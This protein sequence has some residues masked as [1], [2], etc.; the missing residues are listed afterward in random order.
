[1]YRV[2]III[3]FFS[4]LSTTAQIDSFQFQHIS[5]ED[6]LSQSSAIAIEQDAL[7]QMW[8]GTRDG[9]NVYDGHKITVF[10][11]DGENENS[12]S[13]S[14]ILSLEKDHKGQIWIGT[15]NGLNRYNPKTNTFTK[16]LKTANNNS[17]ASNIIQEVYST[18]DGNMWIGTSKGLS[19][20]NPEENTFYNGVFEGVLQDVVVYSVMEL[21]QDSFLIGT[22]LG[23]WAVH[24]KQNDSYEVLRYDAFHDDD[25]TD[26]VPAGKDRLFIGTKSSGVL[27]YDAI[28]NNIQPFKVNEELKI[29]D[30]RKLR[31]DKNNRLW[32]GSY[33]GIYIYDKG[34]VS[35]LI[36]NINDP[37]SLA[38]NSVKSL[39]ED[40]SGSIWVGTH[41]G[42]ANI[43]NEA[44][45]NFQ[46]YVQNGTNK[47]LN[48]S[49]VNS[50]QLFENQLFIGTEQG[51]V[52]VLDLEKNNF[53]YITSDNSALKENDIKSL[54]L[55]GNLLY[56]GT[57]SKGID[58]YN[59][60][61]KRFIKDLIS[62]PL[63][64]ELPHT[65]VYSIVKD[66][67][68]IYF[69]TS[70]K[71]VLFQSS[72]T[73]LSGYLAT[74]N[75]GLTSDLIRCLLID[76]KDV[77]WIGTQNGLNSLDTTDEISN[78][79]FNKEQDAGFDVLNIYED[80]RHTIW[81]GT[82]SQGLFKKVNN[83]FVK[84][85][86]KWADKD[87]TTIHSIVEDGNGMLWMSSNQ[88]VLK[89]NKNSLKI[90]SLNQQKDG[91]VGNEFSDNA[92]LR[93]AQDQLFFGSV[94]G[95]SSFNTTK[96]RI[97]DYAPQVLI[98]NLKST[99]DELLQFN[100]NDNE[101][102][103]IAFAKTVQINHN[104][105]NFTIEFTMP[106]YHNLTSKTYEYRLKGL[107]IKWNTTVEN[108]ATY[109]IQNA[110]DYQFEVRGVNGDGI[111]SDITKLD[112][113]VIPAPWYSWWAFLLYALAFFAVGYFLVRILKSKTRLQEEL[114]FEQVQL[115]R[116][117]DINEAK[118]QFFTNISH[119]FRT[120]LT[121]ILGPLQQL[122]TDYKGSNLMYK[123]LLTIES[124][125]QQ[126]LQLINRLM[127]FRKL[128]KN[129]F[130]LQAAQG[131]IVKFLKEIYLSFE[132]HAK[133]G[134]YNFDF[135]TTDEE[136]LVY[137]D[138]QKL[139]RAFFNLISNAFKFT[140]HGGT[141]KIRVSRDKNHIFIKVKD[142]GI[143][144]APEKQ[145]KVF[146]RFYE[147]EAYREK[148]NTYTQGTGIGL[149]IAKN[150]IHLHKGTVALKSK[151][152]EGS[153][154]TVA[155]K[156]GKDHLIDKEII[157]DFKFS[158][159]V[160][161]YTDHIDK[162]GTM[163]EVKG[164][165]FINDDEK[166]NV[167]VVED[168]ASL[169]SFMSQLLSQYYNVLEA[170]NGEEAFK[171]IVNNNPDIIISDVVMPKMTGT[172][173]C[174]KVKG[175]A[176]TSHIPVILLTSRTSLIYKIEGLES[177][178]DDYL[179]KPFDIRELQLRV[180]N[181]LLYKAKLKDKF[182]ATDVLSPDEINVSSVDNELMKKAIQIVEDNIP[183]DQFDVPTFC[184]E[185]GVSRTMLFIK[186][187]AW[188]NFTPNEFIQ[189]FRMKR[190]AQLLELGGLNISEVS[191]KV[192][193]RNPKYF[194]KCFQK[195]YG[196]TP[197][198]Y[199]K[200]FSV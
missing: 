144:I 99:S 125:G 77:L 181:L 172:E 7:G 27:V 22:N 165:S 193:F 110:G 100:G 183:N 21:S 33:N 138:R 58:V 70:G 108:K 23:L 156:L 93:L 191:Y 6:G 186:V 176:R 90:L 32:I 107:E 28:A 123:K 133:L 161:Q 195:A 69:G 98:T 141:I 4:T 129:Q 61:E 63:Q 169:R 87:I 40:A 20:Y 53:D 120:P 140:A 71:G 104:Q 106:S 68:K 43:W 147:I 194:S 55:D 163:D 54:F 14:D 60:D 10:K 170:G 192:G 62:K 171:I 143:G 96:I 124:N 41:Y 160:T 57:S 114:K 182:T 187:K 185:L 197:S 74:R 37:Y 135:K 166:L 9:L 15:Y 39:Y 151:L 13:S 154:F 46:N 137:Y 30:I 83:Q 173:L 149:N 50:L 81:A 76:Q 34:N 177:G 153:S 80:S 24:K 56:I 145:E 189:H 72:T 95:I 44:N 17:L 94:A 1:M 97:D 66:T 180:K 86:L 198:I 175:D 152:D 199:S 12:L 184:S 29:N 35:H 178:A 179:S 118:L 142:S 119:E 105:R 132:E 103:N 121:L 89:L 155:L 88:G 126:L 164:L 158:D 82:K 5:T 131:N 85:P 92:V 78:F 134:D 130:E 112:I 75:N 111:K 174:S 167:L 136:I 91:L 26:I 25:F 49:V 127:D 116:N 65:G 73:G 200:K 84:I 67:D 31:L 109:A 16:F 150:I 128:E 162:M 64:S 2:L 196:E 148:P 146:D 157:A 8:I 19:I 101:V 59:I 117:R 42:G 79:L 45:S 48:Y 47:G 139:E 102:E 51:G 36:N 18:S 11:S 52:N 122:L 159:D 115:Q 168:N 3:L 38:K 113:E 188:T 190:A